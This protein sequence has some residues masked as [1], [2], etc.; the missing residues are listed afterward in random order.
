M[1]NLNTP[2]KL[3]SKI[4]WYWSTKIILIIFL[5]SLPILIINKDFWVFSF[6]VLFI[7]IGFPVIVFLLLYYHFLNF[8]VEEN[9]ITINSGIII[10]RSESIPFENIQNVTNVRGIFHQLFGLSKINI[11]TASPDQIQAYKGSTIN[12]PAGSLDLIVEDG[13]WLKNFILNKKK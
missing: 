5:L 1:I 9:K 6:S 10:K 8:T 3:P 7:F 12:R 2:N 13:D 4:K 11:W